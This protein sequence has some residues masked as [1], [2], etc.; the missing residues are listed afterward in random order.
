MDTLVEVK[1]D[2]GKGA[3]PIA[4]R[5]LVSG[6]QASTIRVG[7]TFNSYN[8]GLDASY[9]A[10]NT[11]LVGNHGESPAAQA[12]LARPSQ[13]A[14]SRRTGYAG[15]HLPMSGRRHWPEQP[16]AGKHSQSQPQWR[17]ATHHRCLRQRLKPALA[18]RR[19]DRRNRSSC[20]RHPPPERATD[21]RPGNHEQF[22]Q[23]ADRIV[24][25][26]VVRVAD[27][28]TRRLNRAIG[29]V[30]RPRP[31]GEQFELSERRHTNKWTRSQVAYFRAAIL[32]FQL[33]P[34]RFTVVSRVMV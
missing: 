33:W 32:T 11:S 18:L 26:A 25:G 5:T 3:H 19:P 31:D 24:A 7:Y 20:S 16:R 12:H 28:G 34:V 13:A 14:H 1:G 30:P 15:F 4:R 10:S 2:T 23:V 29:E 27:A 21:R 6:N 22:R 8:T 17:G 9:P